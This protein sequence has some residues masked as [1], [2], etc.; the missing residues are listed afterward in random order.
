MSTISKSTDKLRA[1]LQRLREKN[2]RLR[3]TLK[4]LAVSLEHFHDAGVL[5]E[6]WLLDAWARKARA[7]LR[8][9]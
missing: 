8:A 5:P 6:E 9:Q 1:E 4:D 2:K 7:A 3:E